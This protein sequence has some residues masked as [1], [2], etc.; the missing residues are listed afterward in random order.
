MFS[1]DCGHRPVGPSGGVSRGLG[2]AMLST[3]VPSCGC[4]APVPRPSSRIRRRTASPPATGTRRRGRTVPAGSSPCRVRRQP[5]RSP[6]RPGGGRAT[7]AVH[8]RGGRPT[9]G[10]WCRRSR[11]LR[12]RGRETRQRCPART[13]P[14]AVAPSPE[15]GRATPSA[16]AG[17]WLRDVALLDALVQVVGQ[18]CQPVTDVRLGRSGVRDRVELIQL[19]PDAAWRIAAVL[20]QLS[21]RLRDGPRAGMP[22]VT[23]IRVQGATA[24]LRGVVGRLPQV[25]AH[26][27]VQLA[28]PPVVFEGLHG[29]V[30]VTPTGRTGRSCRRR[31]RADSSLRGAAPRA[32]RARRR[33]YARPA[34]RPPAGPPAHGFLTGRPGCLNGE[35]DPGVLGE[36]VVDGLFVG[37]HHLLGGPLGG[38]PVGIGGGTGQHGAS[39]QI[40]WSDP[41]LVRAANGSVVGEVPEHADLSV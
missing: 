31:S 21:L 36:P 2:P 39:F 4:G 3:F 23:E 14:P 40:T 10:L 12:R 11:R 29:H 17:R 13:S 24:L 22:G 38:L 37:G 6:P 35:A 15:N 30:R 41:A 19:L 1:K 5:G 18:H 16:S 26:H 34:G 33:D 32:P 27:L 28:V 8:P 7:R 9:A 20:A 25:R